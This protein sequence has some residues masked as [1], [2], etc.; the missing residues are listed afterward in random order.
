[1]PK[2]EDLSLDGIYDVTLRAEF[3]QPSDYT[4]TT[5]IPIVNEYIFQIEMIDPCYAS[6]MDP[7]VINDM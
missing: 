1:M 2:T 7:L 6:A 4:K 5:M 3:L